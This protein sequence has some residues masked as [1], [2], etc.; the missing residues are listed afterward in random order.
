MRT[1]CALL[2]SLML[3]AEGA[4]AQVPGGVTA[5]VMVGRSE[6]RVVRD[7]E[8]DSEE[9]AGVVLGAWLEAP[10]PTRFLTVLAEAAFAQRGGGWRSFSAGDVQLDPVRG[11]FLTATV[12]PTV[13]FGVGRL[14][15]FAYGGPTMELH[16]R[17]RAGVR[18]ER[19][20]RE[21]APQTLAVTG[22]VGAAWRAGSWTVRAEARRVAGLSA[23]WANEDGDF[24]HRGGELILRVG[25]AL[26]R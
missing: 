12:A 1:L 20:F 24:K 15:V 7:R 2:V 11:D 23:S 19:A 18:I 9:R 17:T 6:T 8:S 14:S 13:R 4:R 10:L 3:L 21:P 25:R 16:V 22:G 26:A 5:G